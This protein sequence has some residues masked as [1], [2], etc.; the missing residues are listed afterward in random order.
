MDNKKSY[1]CCIVHDY[2]CICTIL[3]PSVVLTVLTYLRVLNHPI[4]LI[5]ICSARLSLTIESTETSQGKRHVLIDSHHMQ[6]EYC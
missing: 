3:T 4:S 6:S 2:T 5:R 1:A